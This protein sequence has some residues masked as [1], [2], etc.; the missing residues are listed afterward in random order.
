MIFNYVMS[1]NDSFTNRLGNKVLVCVYISMIQIAKQLRKAVQAAAVEI[2]Q[3]NDRLSHDELVSICAS[4]TKSTIGIHCVYVIVFHYHCF[5]FLLSYYV[6][7][8][9]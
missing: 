7:I 1:L 8:H 3:H 6:L 2:G 4:T 5:V 9:I